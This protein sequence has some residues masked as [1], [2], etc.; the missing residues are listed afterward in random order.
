MQD[1]SDF[2]AN[3]YDGIYQNDKSIL[4]FSIEYNLMETW[5]IPYPLEDKSAL[6]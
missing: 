2:I 1:G 5:F 6:I 3:N 4:N